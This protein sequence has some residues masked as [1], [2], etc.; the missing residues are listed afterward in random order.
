VKANKS[1]GYV[2]FYK[3]YYLCKKTAK[4]R[5][6]PFFLTQEEHKILIVQNC[7]YCDAEPIPFNAYVEKSKKLQ[8]NRKMS[9][10]GISRSWINANTVDR[11]DSEIGYTLKNC[12]PCC[13]MCNMMKNKYSLAAFVDRVTKIYKFYGEKHA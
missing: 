5:D 2:S 11:I 3:L 9:E 6:I 4:D 8:P 1:A 7:R 10:D 12:V 13:L